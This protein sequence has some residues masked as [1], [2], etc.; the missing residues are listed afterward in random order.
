MAAAEGALSAGIGEL[1]ISQ[2]PSATLIAYG[3]GSCVAL[4]AWDPRLR[5]GGLAHFML[6]SGSPD[7][8]G[9][10]APAKFIAGGLETFLAE[11]RAHGLAASRAQLK[12]A[13]G[14]SM[15]MLGGDSLE[16]GRRNADALVAALQA[17][18]LRLAASDLGGRVGRTVQ[19][20]VGSG[21]VTVRSVAT[22]TDL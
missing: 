1:V 12:A 11:L 19:L 5:I 17:A 21:R 2:D 15:L 10:R 9:K 13:G 4:T 18:G 16:I 7:Q 3:L 14:A 6:P 22:V 8:A 20:D